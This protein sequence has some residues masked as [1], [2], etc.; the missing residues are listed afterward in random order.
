M[1]EKRKFSSR[2]DSPGQSVFKQ[3]LF[4]LS[5]PTGSTSDPGTDRVLA[6]DK[7]GRVVSVI[8]GSG[9]GGGSNG[10]SG[11]SGGNVTSG[12]SGTSGTAGLSRT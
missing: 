3:D 1:A 6:T 5:V 2:R 12:T 8:G 7:D 9:G 10:T 4:L 11:S